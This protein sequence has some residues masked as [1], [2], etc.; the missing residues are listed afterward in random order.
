MR[1]ASV[2]GVV[3]PAGYNDDASRFFV[4]VLQE[5]EHEKKIRKVIDAEIRLEAII[6]E[7]LALGMLDCGVQD[8]RP[9]WRKGA[10]G[11][12]VIDSFGTCAD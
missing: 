2:E 1:I 10:T 5:K 6:C 8:K 3:C 11:Y 4:H 7:D 9:Y 12:T